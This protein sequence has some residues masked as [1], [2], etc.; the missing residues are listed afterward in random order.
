MARLISVPGVASLVLVS[1]RSEIESLIDHPAL[2][3]VFVSEGRLVNRLLASRLRRQTEHDGKVLDAFRSRDDSERQHRQRQLRARLDRRAEDQSWPSA[4]I[5]ELARY[6]IEGR[7][8][9]SAEAAL[10]YAVA[11]PFLDGVREAPQDDAYK[12]I[13]R[14]LWRLHRRTLRMRNPVSPIG[15]AMRLLRVDRR[16]RAAILAYTAGDAY[17]LHAVEITLANASDILQRMRAVMRDG[18][19]GT[20][21]AAREL[22][23]AAIRTAPELVVRQ[24]GRD[25]TTLPHVDGRIPPRTLVLLRMRESLMATSDA[26]SGYEFASAHWSACPARRYVTGLFAAVGETAIDLSR[27]RRRP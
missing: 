13:G 15:T 4:L 10:A 12:P 24:S 20:A 5:G 11:W 2:D 21:L 6:V 26:D 8:R 14:H 16:T 25:P 23:W 27:G 1:R 22:T 9:R 17:G 3:R 19:A 7:D 18:P